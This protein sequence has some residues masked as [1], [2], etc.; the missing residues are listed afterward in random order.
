MIRHVVVFTW[1]DGTR[2]EQVHA[3]TEA[4]SRLPSA[5]DVIRRYEV[6]PDLGLSDQNGHFAVVA[7]VDD[8]EAFA[9]Y[10]DHPAHRAVIAEHITPMVASRAAV[11][12]QVP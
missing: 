5:I 6:G 11:Q 12:Y 10:R 7:D 1:R 2:P 8:V 3:L 9:A 4:L